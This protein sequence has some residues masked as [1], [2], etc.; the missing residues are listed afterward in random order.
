MIVPDRIFHQF[1]LNFIFLLISVHPL[2]VKAMHIYAFVVIYLILHKL[3]VYSVSGL[4]ESPFF[5][6]D[7]ICAKQRIQ[8]SRLASLLLADDADGVAWLVGLAPNLRMLV[9]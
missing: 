3:V 5:I 4:I 8:Q 1:N 7:E 2:G 9:Y 6:L